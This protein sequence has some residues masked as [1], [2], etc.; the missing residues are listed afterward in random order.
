MQ[1]MQNISWASRVYS[2]IKKQQ[3][4]ISE[5]KLHTSALSFPAKVMCSC[6]KKIK[7]NFGNKIFSFGTVSKK[8]VSDLIKKLSGNKAAVSNDIPVSVLKESVSA[9]Y[10]KLTDIF[11]NCVR[12]VTF[13]E[14]LKKAEVK[15][16]FEKGDTTSK[17]DYHPVSS[18]SNFSK[19]FEKL[20]YWQLS[21][22]M[23]NKF[24]IYLTGFRKNHVTQHALLKMIETWKTKLNMGHEVGEIN[25]ALFKA[26]DSLNVMN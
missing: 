25:M 26:F 24:S 22:Y 23:E 3:L 2:N 18:L 8:D 11:K 9:Y 10:E 6:C 13:P 19:I 14:I 20:I 16:V 5:I 21:N 17:T 4:D 12:S 15:P 7:E 1:N